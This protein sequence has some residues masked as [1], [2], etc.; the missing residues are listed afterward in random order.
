MHVVSAVESPFPCQ[1]QVFFERH[2]ARKVKNQQLGAAIRISISS[3]RSASHAA[4]YVIMKK[5]LHWSRS[6]ITNGMNMLFWGFFVLAGLLA[7]LRLFL[8]SFKNVPINTD[9]PAEEV[10]YSRNG[11]KSPVFYPKWTQAES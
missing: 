7:R 1:P 3:N 4:L 10:N 9:I 2:S 5:T 11:D 8:S 6:R